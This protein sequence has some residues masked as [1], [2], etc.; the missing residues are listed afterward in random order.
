M[1]AHPP[2]CG[3]S[4]WSTFR[5]DLGIEVVNVTASVRDYRLTV[6]LSFTSA[7]GSLSSATGPSSW[8]SGTYPGA[9]VLTTS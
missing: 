6:G 4:R 2:H 1:S 8:E 3:Q 5:L 7:W 9:V